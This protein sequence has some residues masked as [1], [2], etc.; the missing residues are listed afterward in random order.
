[1]LAQ[2][3]RRVVLQ[4]RERLSMYIKRLLSA[5]LITPSTSPWASPIVVIIKVNGVDIRLCI[6]YQ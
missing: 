6:D 4:F 3:Y 5:V 1:M 2:R